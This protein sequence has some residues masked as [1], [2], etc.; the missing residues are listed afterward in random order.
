MDKFK[1]IAA[2]SVLVALTA[3]ASQTDKPLI[4]PFPLRLP[5]AEVGTLDIDGH[6]V[7]QP[8]A[9]DGIVYYATSEGDL[10][11]VVV[12]SQTIFWR[13]KAD[14]PLI[15]G[16][17]LGEDRIVLR[18]DAN[19]IY[20]LDAKGALVFKKILDEPVTTAVRTKDGKLYFG[21]SGGKAGALDIAAGGTPLWEYRTP[22]SEAAVMAGPVFVGDRVVFGTADGRILALGEDGSPVWEFAADGAIRTDPVSSGGRLYFGTEGCRF[23]CLKATKGRKIWSRRL[24]GA[25]VQPA[26]VLDRRLVV[27]ASNSVVYFLASRGGSIVS[28]EPVPSRIIY[29]PVAA[30]PFVL[31]SAASPGIKSLNALTGSRVGEHP[32][33]GLVVAGAVWSPPFVI[34]FE[35]DPDSGRQRL[36]VFK[37]R[38]GP[39]D[40]ARRPGLI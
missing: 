9:R 12:R 14:H 15:A 20:V 4:D 25:P 40:I 29:E 35:E 17:E 10:T 39:V 36:A 23:Y 26:L 3:C 11:A 19:T 34:L 30:D 28:W 21:T 16:P 31:V 37:S 7:G 2:L 5:L 38:Q 33:A 27:A 1:T 24:Q 32:T 13:F 22:G 6:V 18:D 8:R